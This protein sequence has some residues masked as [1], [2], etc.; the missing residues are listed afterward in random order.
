MTCVGIVNHWVIF[1]GGVKSQKTLGVRQV[2]S[3][4]D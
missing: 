3:W 2:S 1:F 4:T